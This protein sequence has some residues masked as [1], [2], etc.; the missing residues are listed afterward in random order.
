MVKSGHKGNGHPPFSEGD[1]FNG[2]TVY[3]LDFRLEDAGMYIY[4]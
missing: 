1:P 3:P 2:Y 4:L